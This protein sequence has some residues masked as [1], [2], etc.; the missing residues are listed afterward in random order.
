MSIVVGACCRP[1]IE[2]SCERLLEKEN[3]TL[4][5]LRLKVKTLLMWLFK[6]LLQ[7][8]TKKNKTFGIVIDAYGAGPFM[9]ATKSRGWLLQKLTNVQLI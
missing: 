7:K 3:F 5:M 4:W 6:L 8:E 9:V 1:E 2:R